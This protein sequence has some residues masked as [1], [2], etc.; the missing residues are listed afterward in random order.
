MTQVFYGQDASW[1]HAEKQSIFCH[2][3]ITRAPASSIPLQHPKVESRMA[4]AI[5]LPPVV[6]NI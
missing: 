4:I 1:Q 3:I 6:L 5:S 2:R